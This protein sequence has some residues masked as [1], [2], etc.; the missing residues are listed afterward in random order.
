MIGRAFTLRAVVRLPRGA[1]FVRE[2]VIRLTGAPDA[3]CWILTWHD[4]GEDF[5]GQSD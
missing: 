4:G 1:V 5:V 3:P 2:A